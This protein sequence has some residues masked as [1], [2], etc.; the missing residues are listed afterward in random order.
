MRKA[1]KYILC[2]VFLCAFLVIIISKYDIGYAVDIG[3]EGESNIDDFE[4]CWEGKYNGCLSRRGYIYTIVKK[5]NFGYEKVSNTK[6][7]TLAPSPKN[8]LD[9]VDYNLEWGTGDNY[10]GG[11]KD[12]IEKG[13]NLF[14]LIYNGTNANTISGFFDETKNYY[15]LVEPKFLILHDTDNEKTGDKYT[16]EVIYDDKGN[17]QYYGT[18]SFVSKKLMNDGEDSLFYKLDGLGSVTQLIPCT[19]YLDNERADEVCRSTADASKYNYLNETI[20]NSKFGKALIK[21][22]NIQYSNG[23]LTITKVNIEGNKIFSEAIFGIYSDSTC[24]TKIGDNLIVINGSGFKE[25]SEGTYYIKELKAPKSYVTPSQDECTKFQIKQSDNSWK[26]ASSITISSNSNVEIRVKNKQTCE[27]EFE[28]LKDKSDKIA[29]LKL[30]EKYPNSTNLLN[31]EITSVEKGVCGVATCSYNSQKACFSV[32]LGKYGSFSSNNLSCFNE[33]MT[34]TGTNIK[35]LCNTSFNLSNFLSDPGDKFGYIHN[36][37]SGNSFGTVYS[38]KMVVNQNGTV[39]NGTINKQCY[40]YNTSLGYTEGGP[41]TAFIPNNKYSTYV[42][43]VKFG[44]K[45]LRSTETNK[46]IFSSIKYGWNEASVSVGYGF[47]PVYV[48]NGSGK[49]KSSSC[50]NCKFLGYGFL[51]KITDTGEVKLPFNVKMNKSVFKRGI[52]E[53]NSSVCTYEAIP[54]IINKELNIVF[55][56][57]D[58]DNPFVGKLGNERV[59]GINWRYYIG[60]V[61]KEKNS[62]SHIVMNERNNSYNQLGTEPLYMIELTPDKIKKIRNYNKGKEYGEYDFT[63]NKN[64]DCTSNFLN[65]IDLNGAYLDIFTTSDRERANLSWEE[66]YNNK[67]TGDVDSYGDVIN[68][69]DANGDGNVDIKDVTLIEKNVNLFIDDYNVENFNKKA[70][71]LNKDG[72]VNLD[73]L[74]IIKK[75]ISHVNIPSFPLEKSLYEIYLENGGTTDLLYVTD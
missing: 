69:G 21:A 40:F 13:S 56:T 46:N 51:S 18:P 36:W 37:L 42:S 10:V 6:Q 65:N 8:P 15:I 39:A 49:V 47:N 52:K 11:L 31:F 9:K 17:A 25:L 22:S 34:I 16:N 67:I 29:R 27:S 54:Q 30:F 44:N 66:E 70:A 20:N 7:Y 38:G 64:G 35:G 50:S 75:Y 3:T 61:N 41:I 14:K 57:I 60:D 33:E 62:I 59:S 32:S 19:L 43:S 53:N 1:F 73:D 4:E 71:D 55:R 24:T 72:L 74:M 58:T 2:F 23:N 5:T 28:A 63:C 48:E 26:D 68:Y 45:S 12:E